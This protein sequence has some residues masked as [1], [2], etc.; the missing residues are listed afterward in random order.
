MIFLVIFF[1]YGVNNLK[2]KKL[3]SDQM[4][5]NRFDP[6]H[7]SSHWRCSVR[8]GFLRNLAKFTGKHLCQ[9]LYFNKVAGLKLFYQNKD[10]GTGAFQ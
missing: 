5:R 10:S 6:I 4:H 2:D 8:K 1:Y 3:F 7:R 9:S